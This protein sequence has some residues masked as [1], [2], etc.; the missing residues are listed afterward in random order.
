[1]PTTHPGLL[2][3][4]EHG[5]TQA[6]DAQD[7]ATVELAAL[8][9]KILDHG[10]DAVTAQELADAAS[11]VEHAALATSH[12]RNALEAAHQADRQQQLEALK[13]NILNTAGS[14][15]EAV[16]AMRKL[17]EAAAYLIA[18]TSGRP[19]LIAQG[20]ANM[21]R[22]AVPQATAGRAADGHAGLGWYD[23]GLGRSDGLLIDGRN[24]TSLNPGILI[25]A[26]IT[27]AARSQGYTTHHLAPALDI[28][29][30]GGQA[31]DDPETY[32]RTRY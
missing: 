18:M 31:V 12:A 5:L 25:A 8:K 6:Q 21:R 9:Q 16:E 3:D 10:P 1:M 11:Q 20:T 15:D 23:A 13:D 27:R 7:A 32:L 26:A 17:E 4:T 28:N 2:T 29:T 24:I 14:P 22:L 30:P 19:Q